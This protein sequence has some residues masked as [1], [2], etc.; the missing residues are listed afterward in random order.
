ME[1]ETILIN[2]VVSDELLCTVNGFTEK[3]KKEPLFFAVGDLTTE[4][5]YGEGV[6]VVYEDGL[7]I[8]KDTDDAEFVGMDEITSASVKRMY[9]NAAFYVEKTDGEKVLYMRFTLTV[10]ECFDAVANFVT[11]I[12]DG[13]E[14]EDC[15]NSVRHVYDHLESY[16]PKCNARLPGPG[17]PCPRCGKHSSSFSILTGYMKPYVPVLVISLIISVITTFASLLPP[18][19]TSKLVDEIIPN[20]DLSA[21]LI[22]VLVLV[23]VYLVQTGIG[24]IRNYL[25]R[26]AGTGIMCNLKKDIYEKAQY[27]PMKFYDKTTTGGVINRVNSDTTVL[28]SFMMTLSQDAI[29]QFFTMIGIVVI[30]FIMNWKLT[31]LALVTVPFVAILS[32]T[33]GKLIAPKYIR[34]WKKNYRISSILSDT[35]PAIRV[36]KAFTGEKKSEEKFD[37][38]VDDYFEEDKSIGK[39]A[40]TFPAFITFLIMCGSVLIWY[41][42]GRMVIGGGDGLT[43][44]VLVS[45]IS[46]TGMF[47]APINFFANLS[48]TYRNAAA[49]AERVFDI[50]RA[51]PEHDFAK[52]NKVAP[53]RGKIE[54]RDINFSFDRTKKVL[55]NVS[56]VINPGDVV[57]IVGTTGS[58]KTT[59]I[60]LIMRYYDDYEG[61][62]LVDDTDIRDIDLSQYRDQIGY[63][64]QEPVMFN[65]TI[66]NNIAYSRPNASVE[67]V[68][69]AA[70]VA[71]AHDF[72]TRMPDAYDTVVGAGGVSLSGGEKQ[73]LS[74]AR[75]ILR[76]PAILIFD[77]ATSAVDSETEKL[78]QNAIDK[79]TLGRTTIM[80]AH[81]LSTLKKANKI[82]VVDGGRIIEAGPP[83]E[84]LKKKGKYYRLVNIQSMSEEAAA[85]K[86][87]E[88]IDM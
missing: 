75:A 73:R 51:E 61:S 79:M 13:V 35:I 4:S 36:V 85:A 60:N 70:D 20:K 21:L 50:I 80:I 54:F 16:C 52:G 63:V 58:G 32:K 28:K 71:N 42:G 17:K 41:F 74:I 34:L 83:E 37:R 8:V 55:S 81:R 66:F 84:L 10:A 26:I 53:F 6:T 68:M 87:A 29:I 46:Y 44:G 24:A 2:R 88:R 62:I 69:G 77:E 57:G 18:Y 30:M 45:F 14:L 5:T 78:I 47:Y 7:L 72:I 76:N 15:M 82:I 67:E 48:D 33:L 12:K 22:V 3:H 65:D 40:V 43:L 86:T 59:M 64:Q 56:F 49:S 9:G 38:N 11:K 27:L 25:L 31:L 19:I 39:I 1:S 23:G